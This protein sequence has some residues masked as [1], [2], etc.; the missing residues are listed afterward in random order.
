M[1]GTTPHA[2]LSWDFRPPDLS[3]VTVKKL[4]KPVAPPGAR[5][6]PMEVTRE[7]LPISMAGAF[8]FVRQ[9]FLPS[10]PYLYVNGF[11]PYMCMALSF[12]SYKRYSA[13]LF[14]EPNDWPVHFHTV[15]QESM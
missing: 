1:K 2:P 10:S 11:D 15:V 3:S 9:V 4:F 7:G 6:R 5:D 12:I 8:D 13:G 14:G